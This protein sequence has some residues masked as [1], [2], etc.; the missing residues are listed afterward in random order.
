MLRLTLL[1][2]GPDADDDQR[3]DYAPE[4]RCRLIDVAKGEIAVGDEQRRILLSIA[5]FVIF[6]HTNIDGNR[7]PAVVSVHDLIELALRLQEV[8]GPRCYSVLWPLQ[9]SAESAQ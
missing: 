4:C 9:P 8:P 3:G 2:R 5:G 1:E 6:R 7:R